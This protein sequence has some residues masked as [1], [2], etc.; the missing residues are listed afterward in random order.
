MTRVLA[1]AMS[2]GSIAE[3]V[4]APLGLYCYFA[5]PPCYLSATSII[6]LPVLLAVP[7][8]LGQCMLEQCFPGFLLGAG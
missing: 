5:K 3:I 6:E 7:A 8:G 2:G 4:L 1:G